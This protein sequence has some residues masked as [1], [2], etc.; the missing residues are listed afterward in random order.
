MDGQVDGCLRERF[1]VILICC[2]FHDWMDINGL[3]LF[4]LQ[5]SKDYYLS[6]CRW[7]KGR[8]ERPQSQNRPATTAH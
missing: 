1:R 2:S 3:H 6:L 4:H 7:D 5:F 8:S